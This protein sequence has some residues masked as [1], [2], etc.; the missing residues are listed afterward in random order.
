[1][2]ELVSSIPEWVSILA[3]IAVCLLIHI[4]FSKS[5]NKSR[6]S[7]FDFSSFDFSDSS[8]SDGGD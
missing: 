5:S 3:V 1:M 6:G 7:G 4:A 2:F 8:G